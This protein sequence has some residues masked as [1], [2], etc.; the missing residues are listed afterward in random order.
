K[1]RIE[2]NRFDISEITDANVPSSLFKFWLRDLA[3]PLIPSEFYDQCIK[4]C[5]DTNLSIE[6]VK[7]LPEINRRVVLCPSDNLAVIFENTKYEQ[8]YVKTLLLNLRS[9]E[10]ESDLEYIVNDDL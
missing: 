1:L 8:T 9:R 5:D 3:D 6:I 4:N 7:K 2:K 10:V